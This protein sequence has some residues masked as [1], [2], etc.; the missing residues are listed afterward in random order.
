MHQLHTI[1]KV[2]EEESSQVIE[3]MMKI[4]KEIFPML[5]QDE[6]P[7]DLLHFNEYY[8]RQ[9]SSAIFAAIIEDGTV[10]GTIGIYQYDGRFD[11]LQ[12]FYHH[13]RTAE[14]VKCYI[15][16]QYRRLGLG[17]ILFN[18]ALRFC[19]EAAYEKLYLHTHP[20]LP[21]AIPFW[22]SKGFEERLAEDDPIWKTLHMDMQL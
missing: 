11:Q 16:P 10:V 15:D 21:G 7:Q 4:R 14:I 19:R 1:R 22:K 8:T 6:L 20:F 12:E 2:Q 18:Q 13:S 9:E 5:S 17:S 3:F